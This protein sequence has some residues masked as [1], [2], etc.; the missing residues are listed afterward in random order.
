MNFRRII[1]NNQIN[2]NKLYSEYHEYP[3]YLEDLGPYS[4]I[5][6][7]IDKYPHEML[8]CCMYGGTRNTLNGYFI[9]KP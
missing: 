7:N 6:I 3:F 9:N 1:N 5:E 4:E 2:I 8:C